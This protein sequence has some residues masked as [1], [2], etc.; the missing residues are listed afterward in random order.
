MQCSGQQ[1]VFGKFFFFLLCMTTLSTSPFPSSAAPPLCYIMHPQKNIF[2]KGPL[3]R[4]MGQK[5]AIHESKNTPGGN[6]A[7]ACGFMAE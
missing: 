5:L 1:K 3:S 6:K 4:T 2:E 7:F